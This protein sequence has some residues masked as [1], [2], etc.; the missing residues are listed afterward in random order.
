MD[1]KCKKYLAPTI[2]TTITQFKTAVSSAIPTC[3]GDQSRKASDLAQVVEH[4]IEVSGVCYKRDLG[5]HLYI[6]P[7]SGCGL[8]LRA[9]AKN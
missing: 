6:P 3:L 7:L 1:M 8:V 2:C 9:T 5:H 4:W